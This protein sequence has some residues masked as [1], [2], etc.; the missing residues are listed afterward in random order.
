VLRSRA[1]GRPSSLYL[2]GARMAIKT[3]GCQRTGTGVFEKEHWYKRM[4]INGKAVG[5]A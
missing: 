5:L 4:G 3:A 1:N 2:A